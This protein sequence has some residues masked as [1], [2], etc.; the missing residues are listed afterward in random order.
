MP[1]SNSTSVNL[2]STVKL[3][4]G[5]ILVY[6]AA[7]RQPGGWKGWV[8]VTDRRVVFQWRQR[9]CG[10]E[11]GSTEESLLLKD[12]GAA[13]LE[14]GGSI[15]WLQFGIFF[16]VLGIAVFLSDP[17]SDAAERSAYSFWILGAILLLVYFI[18]LLLRK[19][20][21]VVKSM[22]TGSYWAIMPSGQAYE[23]YS[24]LQHQVCMYEM[25]SVG[26]T[27]MVDVQPMDGNNMMQPAPSGMPNLQQQG[28]LVDSA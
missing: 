19:T 9:S 17:E 26:S 22:H 7:G 23:A 1:L 28:K 2:T 12:I 20:S 4:P 10:C 21:L 11:M 6:R 16:V 14:T 24:A 3:H 5:E 13:G 18:K 8:S 25:R 15:R 27:T